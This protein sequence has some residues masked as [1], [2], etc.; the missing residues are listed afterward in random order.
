MSNLLDPVS[1]NEKKCL[2]L[3]PYPDGQQGTAHKKLPVC[4]APSSRNRKGQASSA[5]IA[6][7]TPVL[8]VTRLE[9]I[10]EER[11]YVIFEIP[12]DKWAIPYLSLHGKYFP[13]SC[14]SVRV[15]SSKLRPPTLT[16]LLLRN[17]GCKC[18]LDL[19]HLANDWKTR[20]TGFRN[21]HIKCTCMS[22][23]LDVDQQAVISTGFPSAFV[24]GNKVSATVD[25]RYMRRSMPQE[26]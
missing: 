6:M 25:V 5:G 20:R 18:L 3:W 22:M 9:A 1:G 23:S 15:A 12:H 16:L 7:L 17:D 4:L 10:S 19:C 11:G 24:M 26:K 21:I 13:S 8:K 14:H 2:Q